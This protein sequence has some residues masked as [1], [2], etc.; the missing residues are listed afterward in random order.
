MSKEEEPDWSQRDPSTQEVKDWMKERSNTL[1]FG[2]GSIDRLARNAFEHFHRPFH[3]NVLLK[4]AS[5]MVD[6]EA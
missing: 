3:I 1:K 2:D 5:E 6:G 4:W